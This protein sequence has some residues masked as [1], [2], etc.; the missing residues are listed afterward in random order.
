MNG[1][2]PMS[3]KNNLRRISRLSSK[4]WMESMRRNWNTMLKIKFPKLI[5]MY[6]GRAN[7]KY[8]RHF[9]LISFRSRYKS[10]TWEESS[11]TKWFFS[12]RI[13]SCPTLLIL[14]SQISIKRIG[15]ILYT[16]VI[17]NWSK[18]TLIVYKQS[19][20]RPSISVSSNMFLSKRSSEMRKGKLRDLSLS[21]YSIAIGISIP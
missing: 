14:I 21:A 17:G 9:L 6:E 18:W 15:V 2:I 7:F 1:N 20:L 4:N 16:R 11:M 5:F 12:S 3:M 10:T 19:P 13:A 8:Q